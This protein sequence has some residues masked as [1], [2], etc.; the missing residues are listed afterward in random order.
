MNT[1]KYALLWA[2]GMNFHVVL[3]Q[4]AHDLAEEIRSYDRARHAHM[5]HEEAADL[6]DPEA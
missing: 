5:L 2:N 4:Y 1:D 3:E 6:I